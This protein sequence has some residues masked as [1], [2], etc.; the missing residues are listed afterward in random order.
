MG[1]GCD[2]IQFQ[3]FECFP[4]CALITTQNR[5][6]GRFLCIGVCSTFEIGLLVVFSLFY[7]SMVILFVA[8]VKWSPQTRRVELTQV[9]RVYDLKN[10]GSGLEYE[11]YS[12]RTRL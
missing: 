2:F 7:F 12:M 1:I 5:M 9:I 8:S 6:T 11:L 3:H 4:S 10:A